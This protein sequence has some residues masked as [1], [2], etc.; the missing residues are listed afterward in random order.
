MS[1]LS[2]SQPSRM[3]ERFGEK[4][5]EQLSRLLADALVCHVGFT[6]ESGQPM[7]LPTAVA[8]DC[9]RLILHGSTGS[10]WFS[11]IAQGIPVSVAVT[12][13]DGLVVARSAFESSMH[14]RSA[15]LFG[16]C[17]QL[18]DAEKLAALDLLTE[19]LIPGRTSEVRRP[20]NKELAATLVLEM[21]VEEW[22]LKVSDGWPEDSDSDIAGS[23]WAGVLPRIVSYDDAVPAPDLPAGI[24]RP[25]SVQRLLGRL[26]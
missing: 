11:L 12:S 4:G 18:A 20:A 19:A 3:V 13:L 2:R 23:S 6:T 7:V 14:F 9:N 8:G 15:V 10:R 24:A 16:R 1:E 22:T 25:D 17:R 26:S 5:P 21:A